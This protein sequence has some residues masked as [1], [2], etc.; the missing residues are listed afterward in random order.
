MRNA[1]DTAWNPLDTDSF[2]QATGEA[3]AG[4]DTGAS[5]T[6]VRTWPTWPAAGVPIREADWRPPP[7]RPSLVRSAGLVAVGFILSRLLGLA[8][9]IVL[10]RMF[11]TS[12]EY[13]AYV[14]AFRI[15]DLLFLI[16]MAGSFGSAFIPVFSGLIG[17]GRKEAAWR[18]AS[19]VLTLAALVMAVAGLAAF[20][21]ADPLAAAVISRGAD[22]AIQALTAETMRILLL[23]PV[24]LGLGIAAKGILEGQDR[25]TLPAFAP[26]AYNL[27]TILGALLL[28]P[29][30]GVRGV[31]VGV[32]AGALAHLAVQVPGLVGSGL[33]F[34]PSLDLQTE[35]LAEVG[36]LLAPRVVGQ[37]AFQ[38]NF[39]VVTALAWRSG[40]QAVAAL[41]YAWQ[42]L[43][44][45]HGVLALSI[46]TVVFPTM[47]RL[48]A[49]GD[50]DGL[51]AAFG[52][53]LKPLLFLSLPAAIALFFFRDAV[54]QTLLQGGA[55]TSESTRLV[56]APL[57]WFAAG[58]VA[59]AAVE[60]LT[61]AFYA[62]RDTVTPVAAGVAIIVLN[63][64]I[65]LLLI[66]RYGYAVLAFGLSASTAVE[67]AILLA[68]LRGRLGGIAR[69]EWSWL[70]RV[71]LAGGS[72]G[73]VAAALGPLVAGWTVPGATPRA[74]QVVVLAAALGLVGGVYAAAAW[75]LRVPE[76]RVAFA[77]VAN[78]PPGGSQFAVPAGEAQEP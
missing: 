19:T 62:M 61:R 21:L 69:Q 75:L 50:L 14:A 77:K 12:A 38:V 58:L 5:P 68:V 53:A 71:G 45:P 70:A 31:A 36:R 27:A 52:R 43:M 44:L 40:E 2:V 37:A 72:A 30:F 47:S 32:V 76:L 3:A 10:S 26:V 29:R 48:F 41:N 20:A 25:F 66:D 51:R 49:A 18:L 9:E 34:R 42:L 55:F 78:R 1:P 65:G 64:A 13:S 24:F 15:P 54:V 7:P 60:V 39:I 8:R 6:G 33:R 59:Y 35:G 46:S 16:I 67:A 56:A 11:G 28:G 63:V 23:S 17:S 4:D 57:A 73:I 22:P 74:L